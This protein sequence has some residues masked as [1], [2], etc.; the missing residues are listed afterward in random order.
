MEGKFMHKKL[1]ITLM[2]GMS[3][4]S[5]PHQAQAM[6]QLSQS[7][8]QNP[9]VENIKIDTISDLAINIATLT[10]RGVD[11]SL[12]TVIFDV[13]GTLTNHYDPTGYTEE[14]PISPRGDAIETVNWMFAQ[15]VNIIFSSAWDVLG[16]T[17]SRLKKLDFGQYVADD[18]NHET[19]QFNDKNLDVLSSGRAVSVRD[20][21]VDRYYYHQ[22]AFSAYFFD[23][24]IAGKT[25]YLL[26][27]DDSPGNISYFQKDIQQHNIYPNL[28]KV[29]LYT[30]SESYEAP[31]KWAEAEGKINKILSGISSESD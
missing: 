1:C 15:N 4:V 23:K 26:F 6:D 28:Q 3:I 14:T 7:S 19:R 8:E 11:P 12:I 20:R 30:L 31:G 5:L 24:E 18:V 10:S 22:K 25:R 16:E 17:I 13:D 9:S 27:A 21:N 2:L 29:Y